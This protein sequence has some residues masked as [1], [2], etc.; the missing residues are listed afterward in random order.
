M[1][2]EPIDSVPPDIDEVLGWCLVPS[3]DQPRIVVRIG[4]GWWAYGCQQNVTH[5]L[6]GILRPSNDL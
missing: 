2:W 5:Y 4:H 1:E 3:G 6:P